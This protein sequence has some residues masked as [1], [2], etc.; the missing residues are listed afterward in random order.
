[1][2][3]E[4]AG[5]KFSFCAILGKWSE[6]DGGRRDCDVS[7]RLGCLKIAALVPKI[8]NLWLLFLCKKNCSLAERE[9]MD[10]VFFIVVRRK[11]SFFSCLT[12]L[13]VKNEGN[14]RGLAGD[15]IEKR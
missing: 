4:R 5:K 11:K 13:A 15:V 10:E 14:W 9:K 7:R 6:V 3:I 12:I 8:W 1:L 2:C